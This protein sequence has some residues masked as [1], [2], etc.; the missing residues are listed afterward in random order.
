MAQAL[1]AAAQM[2]RSPS[3]QLA[4]AQMPWEKQG[5]PKNY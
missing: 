1:G 2:P 3:S 4:L 5:V